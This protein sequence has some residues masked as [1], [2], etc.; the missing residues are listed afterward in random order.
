MNRLDAH[1]IHQ[2]IGE[3]PLKKP[4]T[5]RTHGANVNS[6]CD[7]PSGK[8]SLLIQ[9][10]PLIRFLLLVFNIPYVYLRTSFTKTD[11]SLWAMVSTQCSASSIISKSK[12]TLRSNRWPESKEQVR[13][14]GKGGGNTSQNRQRVMN[15]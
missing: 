5:D 7:I 15:S 1:F 9:I 2:M 12:C 6:C 10:P 14:R 13:N 8:H 11:R 4:V 3:N